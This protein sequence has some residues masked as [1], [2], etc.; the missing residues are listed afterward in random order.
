MPAQPKLTVLHYTGAETD[1][2]GIVSAIRTL[3]AAEVFSCVL[4]VSPGFT[5]HRSPPLPVL[6]LPAI[7]ADVVGW[8]T[9]WRARAVARAVRVWLAADPNRIFHAHSRAG[10]L[11]AERL[12]A[13]GERRVVASVHC[14]GRQRWFYRRASRRLGSRLFWLSPAMKRYYGIGGEDW[15]QCIPSGVTV[16]STSFKPRTALSAGKVRLGGI[17]MLVSW[18]RWHDVIEALAALPPGVRERVSF[19]HIG[20]PDTT[21]ASRAYA[22]QLRVRTTALGL[23]GC[24]SWLGEQPNSDAL[25]ASVD[26]LLVTSQAEPLS[27]ALLEALRAGVPGLVADSGG[28]VD[29]VRPGETGWT[30]RTGDVADLARAITALVETDALANVRITPETIRS[31]TAPVIAAQWAAVYAGLARAPQ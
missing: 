20:S 2:G 25:L 19:Q 26:C 9:W 13:M 8:K 30:F 31:Y 15:T 22:Q 5:Q 16:R 3:A 4:G 28:V 21:A 18:K 29:L 24:V 10:L 6:E 7:E 11:V 17:G 27:L 1:Q 14:Y 12:V 23:D